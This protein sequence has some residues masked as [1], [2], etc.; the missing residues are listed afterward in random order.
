MKKHLI[1][2][3]A[4]LA[5]GLLVGTAKGQALKH[6]GFTNYYNPGIQQSD[7]TVWQLT[8]AM[9]TCPSKI[10]RTNIFI[11]DPTIPGNDLNIYY[12]GSG[13]DRGH[14]FDADDAACF[15]LMA[16]DCW[17]FTNMVPQ[18]PNLNRITWRGL[19]NYCRVLAHKYN[20]SIVC[21]VSG[22]IGKL[23]GV[24]DKKRPHKSNINIPEYC[25]KRITYNGATE[26]YA[27]PN[28]DTVSRHPFTYYKIKKP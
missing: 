6:N 26:V 17:Y 9:V 16:H 11:A 25:W 27:M 4:M 22:S 8:P 3:A 20:I 14:Q 10:A 1:F 2:W 23:T 5:Y 18:C 12:A 7:S 21:G 28:R 13:Y 15:P 19:E 24:D